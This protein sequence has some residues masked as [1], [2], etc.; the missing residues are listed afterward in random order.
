M[1]HQSLCVNTEC[2]KFLFSAKLRSCIH[3]PQQ[4]KN[5]KWG[6]GG[7]GGN[8]CKTKYGTTMVARSTRLNLEAPFPSV[9]PHAFGFSSECK[10]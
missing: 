9:Q 10:Y 7:K 3:H 6:C 4:D 5:K 1:T 8:Y 2:N